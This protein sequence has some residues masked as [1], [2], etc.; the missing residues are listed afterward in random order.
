MAL[1]KLIKDLNYIQALSDRPNTADGLTSMELKEK[2]DQA[3]ND[4]KNYINN[5]LISEIDK[6]NLASIKGSDSR[7][8]DSRR[9]NNNFDNYKIALSNLH[10][11]SGTKLPTTGE[12][13]DIFFLY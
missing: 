10:I 7:L 1:P 8:T 11:N 6:Q 4:I 12:D 5:E 2:F 13:G 9:C 3:A